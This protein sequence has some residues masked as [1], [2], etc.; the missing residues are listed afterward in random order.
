MNE[1][2][3][4]VMVLFHNF[5]SQWKLELSLEATKVTTVQQLFTLI[6]ALQKKKDEK[7]LNIFIFYIF[8]FCI[9]HTNMLIKD[10]M[11]W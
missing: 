9:V 4:V 5:F 7:R 11:G 6:N 8:V 3:L 10:E 2:G 1:T